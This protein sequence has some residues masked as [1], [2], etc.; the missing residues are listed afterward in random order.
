MSNPAQKRIYA[1]LK[2]NFTLELFI[3]FKMAY[4]F[5]VLQLISFTASTTYCSGRKGAVLS[6]NNN[7]WLD[8]HF[9]IYLLQIVWKDQKWENGP[10]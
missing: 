1:I 3:A 4:S 10:L 8:G 9:H 6:S 5:A 2:Q 7:T